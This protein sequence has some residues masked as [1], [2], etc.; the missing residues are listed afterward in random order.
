MTTLK[1][2]GGIFILLLQLVCFT[3]AQTRMLSRPKRWELGSYV[4]YGV[5]DSAWKYGGYAKLRLAHLNGY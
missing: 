1:K 5:R 3:T 4:G 2:I